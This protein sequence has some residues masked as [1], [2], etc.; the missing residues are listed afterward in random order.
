MYHSMR[1]FPAAP[2]A[3]NLH[4][5]HGT[6]ELVPFVTRTVEWDRNVFVRFECCASPLCPFD[7]L[8][9]PEVEK[10]LCDADYPKANSLYPAAGWSRRISFPFGMGGGAG[11]PTP[12][13][14][15]RPTTR[16]F[17]PHTATAAHKQG[18]HV[19][20]HQGPMTPRPNANTAPT[21]YATTKATRTQNM[22]GMLP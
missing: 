5:H 22:E 12:R 7:R 17:H 10:N 15:A 3:C 18:T 14:G 2:A 19:E 8:P 9:S 13:V 1:I 21:P 20:H 11:H 16:A 6:G 4:N